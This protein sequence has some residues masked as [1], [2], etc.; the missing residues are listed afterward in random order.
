M[1]R[2]GMLWIGLIVAVLVFLD[3]LFVELRRIVR[4]GKRIASRVAGYA[5]LPLLVQLAASERDLERILNALDALAQLIER[6]QIA[7]A[8]LRGYLPKGSSPG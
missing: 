8:V 2:S 1:D 7:L 3:L 4:E 5:E 6:G